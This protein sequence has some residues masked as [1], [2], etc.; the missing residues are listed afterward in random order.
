MEV[1]GVGNQRV[2]GV[3]NI[4]PTDTA[5]R[6]YSVDGYSTGSDTGLVLHNGLVSSTTTTIYLV[7]HNEANGTAHESWVDGVY[8]PDG[9]WLDTIAAAAVTFMVGYSTV[10]A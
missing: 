8:F 10:K 9:V 1:A 3:G 7:V 2:T 5:I 6:I 4:L